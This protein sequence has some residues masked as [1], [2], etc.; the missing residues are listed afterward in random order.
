MVIPANT[1]PNVSALDLT[2]TLESKVAAGV[3][4]SALAVSA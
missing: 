3:V 4:H 1:L 2:Y